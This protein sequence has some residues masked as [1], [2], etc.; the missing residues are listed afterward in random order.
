MLLR[1]RS[2][3]L[4]WSISKSDHSLQTHWTD[5]TANVG[6]PNSDKDSKGESGISIKELKAENVEP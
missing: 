5:G 6:I 4:R 3:H 2:M 1:L